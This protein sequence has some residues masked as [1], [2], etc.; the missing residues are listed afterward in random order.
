MRRGLRSAV[1]TS[2]AAV[3]CAGSL[4][5]HGVDIEVGL[6]PPAVVL[7]AAYSGA[8]ALAYASVRIHAPGPATGEFQIGRADAAGRFAFVPDREGPWRVIVDDELG[9]RE[10]RR[11]E[12]GPEFFEGRAPTAGAAGPHRARLPSWLGALAGVALIFGVSGFL[13]GFKV[14]RASGS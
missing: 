11:V 1:W 2:I 6:H 10:E 13:Y 9:H 3:L 7:R 5:G 12:I 8:E 14:R 4:A